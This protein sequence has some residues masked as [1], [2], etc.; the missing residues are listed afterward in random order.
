MCYMLCFVRRLPKWK[1]HGFYYQ[2][3]HRLVVRKP[4]D[5]TIWCGQIYHHIRV[6]WK[7][8][9]K[10][11]WNGLWGHTRGNKCFDSWKI[12]QF[13]KAGAFLAKKPACPSAGRVSDFRIAGVWILCRME[14]DEVGK[15]MLRSWHLVF[16]STWG[17]T[18]KV[19]G[20]QAQ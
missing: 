8:K 11:V 15:G 1:G 6:Q 20:W 3:V 19:N 2:V 17:Q 10:S 12:Y 5:K 18:G 7:E 9:W 4:V 13:S 14:E 16:W